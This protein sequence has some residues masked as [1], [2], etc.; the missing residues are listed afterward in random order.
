[1]VKHYGKRGMYSRVS[2]LEI[3][4]DPL[5]HCKHINPFSI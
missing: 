2:I 1:M 5:N 4:Q 3:N